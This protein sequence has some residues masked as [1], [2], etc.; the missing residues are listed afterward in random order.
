MWLQVVSLFE[1]VFTQTALTF[2][3]LNNE[4]PLMLL[5]FQTTRLQNLLTATTLEDSANQQLEINL[6]K[7]LLAEQGILVFGV[8]VQLAATVLFSIWYFK[9][10][11][12][13]DFSELLLE[14]VAHSAS[15]SP[16]D[17]PLSLHAL[18]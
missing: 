4:N 8:A 15:P 9:K 5:H 11:N 10:E 7:N 16:C 13:D 3:G 12:Q 6:T 1:G 2:L 18:V 17:L 14:R